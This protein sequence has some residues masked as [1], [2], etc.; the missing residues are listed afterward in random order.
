MRIFLYKRRAKEIRSLYNKST[1][2]IQK[3]FRGYQVRMRLL[4]DWAAKRIQRFMKN[5][6]FF[7]FR[8]SVIMIM[9]LRLMIV[10]KHKC[11]KVIQRYYRGYT[12]RCY[13]FNY[14]LWLIV[15]NTRA[16][17]IQNSFRKYRMRCVKVTKTLP[18]EKWVLENCGRFIAKMIYKLYIDWK[19]REDY[20]N[21]INL[22]TPKIQRIIRGYLARCGTKTMRNIRMIIRAYLKPKYAKEFLD[23]YLEM[24]SMKYLTEKDQQANVAA[25]EETKDFIRNYLPDNKRNRY[26]VDR[27]LFERA[28][29]AWYK[30]ECMPLLESEKKSLINR[31]KN[32]MNGTISLGPVEDYIRL[33]QYPCA[34]HGRK[35][36]GDCVYREHCML[37][38]CRCKM[39]KAPDDNK[40]GICINCDHPGTLHTLKPLQSKHANKETAD[41]SLLQIVN[42]ARA[43]DLSIPVSVTGIPIED[44]IV[45]L[46]DADDIR[47]RKQLE[48]TALT[49]KK[50]YLES[51]RARPMTETL[52]SLEVIFNPT[53][54]FVMY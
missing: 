48:M 2:I 54:L 25:I 52:A 32:P 33:H 50:D 30:D 29:I 3:L 10:K 20:K 15:S 27:K 42:V 4:I 47:Q 24:R 13:V 18:D 26:E 44:A 40:H 45:P 12:G 6:H 39:Y 49:K 22:V 31:F 35:V 9:Q 28:L 46:P 1:T 37:N 19:E 38:S 17:K 16:K 11:A 51:T 53:F 14:R 36:C 7:K 43:P 34:R 5:L 41:I 23:S 21:K 8:D